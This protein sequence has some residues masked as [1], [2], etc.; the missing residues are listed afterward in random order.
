[1]DGRRSSIGSDCARWLLRAAPGVH[2]RWERDIR[3]EIGHEREAVLHRA[4]QG[5]YR[6]AV[7]RYAGSDCSR[8]CRASRVTTPTRR[9]SRQTVMKEDCSEVTRAST[10]ASASCGSARAIRLK[11][12]MS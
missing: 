7:S 9:S 4:R 8:R 10:G 3:Q 6:S 11:G 1:M 12:T 2:G 5:W